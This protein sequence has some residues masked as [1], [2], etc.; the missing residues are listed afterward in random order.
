MITVGITG[1]MGSGK[2]T[3]AKIFTV[4]G[5]PVFFADDASKWLMEND[6][7]LKSKLKNKFGSTIYA[8]GNL[9]RKVLAQIIFQDA[10]S[11]A[12]INKLIH[13]LTVSNFN[14]WLQTHNDSPY[15]LKE[16]AILFESGTYK[17]C[18]KIITVTAPVE[19][20]ISRIQNR[21]QS[22]RKEIESRIH[23]QWTDEQKIS[24]SDFVIVNDDD[25]A[26]IP[27]V[28]QIHDQLLKMN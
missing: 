21:D 20:R 18:D 23:N 5:I 7:E 13:P 10:D 1:G 11:L 2:T 28:M 12:W 24:L 16:A 9:Q 6:E 25:H 19:L 15:V 22:Q 14:S 4:L 17:N 27:Q 26:L 8:D 3:V